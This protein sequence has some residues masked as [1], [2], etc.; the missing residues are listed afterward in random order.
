MLS[1]L[2]LAGRAAVW[3]TTPEP[4]LVGLRVLL[5]VAIL[6]AAV[7]IVLQL[8][9]A[10]PSHAFNP[11][12]LNAI[13][14]WIALELAV[15][16][17]FV[18][19][20]ARVTALS[21][22]FILSIMA[23]LVTSAVRLGLPLFDPDAAESAVW[24]SPITGSTIFAVAVLWWVGAM[25]CVLKSLEPRTRLRALGTAAAM[26]VA[27]FAANA[28]VP[29]APVFVPP[30]FDPH[31]ANWWEVA[32]A[33]YR[34]NY[35]AP[36]QV[37]QLERAQGGLLK[38]EVAKLAPR[39]DAVNVYA[40][41]IAGW[42]EQDVFIKELDGGLDAIA[43]VLP[44][45]GRTI[46]LINNR[47]TLNTAPLATPQNFAAAVRAIGGVMNKDQ[48]VLILF[49]TSH[50]E[51]NGFALQVPGKT[52]ELTPQQVSSAL[53]GEGIKNRVVIVSACFAGIFLPPLAN[54]DTIVL[55]AADATHTS[56]GCA[57]ERDWTY[58]GDAFF[59][60]SLHPG[61]TLAQAFEHAR[62]LI[63]GWEMMDHDP[64][65]NPQ[66]HFGPALVDRLEPFFAGGQGTAQ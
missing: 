1:V 31:D 8:A 34:D 53:D 62:V 14:A 28:A 12:G 64:P 18:R 5:G 60:Q 59:R 50:G 55:T 25:A 36:S 46:K 66:A 26:W 3:T 43:S 6:L 39:K 10:F 49:M 23:D 51:K 61:A 56:F 22:M 29:H 33:Y 19:Q 16:A 9:A 17:L 47:A 4:R 7:R 42:A 32:Y 52:T 41:G 65:S 48:D 57:P 13:I 54:D 27:L 20:G 44:I 40:L 2:K 63:Q 15:A 35:G 21:A 30:D 11:Y 24:T 58:F 38:T 45:K 37:T